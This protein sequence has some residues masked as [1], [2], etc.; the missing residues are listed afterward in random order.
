MQLHSGKLGRRCPSDLISAAPSVC[1][2]QHNKMNS[3]GPLNKP[4]LPKSQFHQLCLNGYLTYERER[5]TACLFQASAGWIRLAPKSPPGLPQ[6]PNEGRVLQV[7]CFNYVFVP[8]KQPPYHLIRQTPPK[9]AAL[10]ETLAGL[11]SLE[12]ALAP[13]LPSIRCS[14][15][16][17]LES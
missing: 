17:N 4:S 13:L 2:K 12:M 8:L 11:P 16:Q 9:F 7:L 6:V 15:R 14:D 3:Q 5:G 1:E 10:V